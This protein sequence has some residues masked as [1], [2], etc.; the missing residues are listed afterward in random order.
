MVAGLSP[1]IPLAHSLH[2]VTLAALATCAWR[3]RRWLIGPMAAGLLAS[4]LVSFATGYFLQIN[5]PS[6]PEFSKGDAIKGLQSNL[7]DYRSALAGDLEPVRVAQ[8]FRAPQYE[9]ATAS[10]QL[11]YMPFSIPSPGPPSLSQS[12]VPTAAEARQAWRL[13]GP[14][15]VA[16][17]EEM[18]RAY[19]TGPNLVEMARDYAPRA[20]V[21]FSYEI[22]V[23]TVVNAAALLILNRRR[24]RK[25][26]KRSLA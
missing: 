6:V 25:S 22:C 20:A 3:S 12:I 26:R 21:S 2:Y 7:A 11:P 1:F 16:G 10:Y 18:L 8:G 14:R 15:Y 9:K 5:T 19:T 4:I 24:T 23:L 17:L 13:H